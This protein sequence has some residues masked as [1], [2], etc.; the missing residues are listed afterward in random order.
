[1]PPPKHFKFSVNPVLRRFIIVSEGANHVLLSDESFT[2]Q[3]MNEYV[4]AASYS[5]KLKKETRP[6]VASAVAI[7]CNAWLDRM[8]IRDITWRVAAGYDNFV[9]GIQTESKLHTGVREWVGLRIEQCYYGRPFKSGKTSLLVF[10]RILSGSFAGLLFSQRL[11]FRYVTGVLAKEIGWPRFNKVYPGEIVQAC[12]VGEVA[13]AEKGT[14][15]E[16]IYPASTVIRHNRTLRKERKVPISGPRKRCPG[17]YDFPCHE[18]SRG[19]ESPGEDGCML[20]THPLAYAKADCSV[21]KRTSFFE[22]WPRA[23]ICVRCER[24][25]AS[26]KVV[27]EAKS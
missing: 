13:F 4:Q 9:A 25:I 3:M 1:M 8:T 12:L 20:A 10:F 6:L 19:Y 26:R 16:E 24:W 7:H 18:C 22:Q 11:P 17:N 5:L 14:K 15:L 27:L 2:P 21:C 23:Q